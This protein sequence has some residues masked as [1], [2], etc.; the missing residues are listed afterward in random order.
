MGYIIEG[1]R[2]ATSQLKL[3]ILSELNKKRI[4]I[5]IKSFHQNIVIYSQKKDKCVLFGIY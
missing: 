1:S 2:V 4:T 5:E 3:N